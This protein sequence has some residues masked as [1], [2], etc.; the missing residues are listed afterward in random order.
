MDWCPSS[1][2]RLHPSAFRLVSSPLRP[3]FLLAPTDSHM[4]FARFL[5]VPVI[6]ACVACNS[7]SDI[8]RPPGAAVADLRIINAAPATTGVTVHLDG[9]SAIAT[10]SFRQSNAVCVSV[11]A[12][13]H[14]LEFR[15]SGT[16]IASTGAVT[17]E[18]EERYTAVLTSLGA[19]AKA[20][21]L[22]DD[23][24]P[25]SG[26]HGLRFINAMATAGD[27]YVFPPSGALGTVV[28]NIPNP[29]ELVGDAE[30]VTRPTTETQVQFFD[31]GVSTGTPRAEFT[32][33]ALSSPRLATIVLTDVGATTAFIV[34]ACP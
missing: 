28:A 26:N 18:D 31:V 21:V 10:L 24:T 12:G 8:T 27:V 20:M 30:Y 1:F 9:G 16:A 6:A 17:F 19:T 22:A 2:F 15:V 3:P 32:V 5:S 23:V 29:A 33:P 7:L 4:R 14:S 34:N 25:G 11:P 13:D